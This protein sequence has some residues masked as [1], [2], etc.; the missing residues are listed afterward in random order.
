MRTWC[1]SWSMGLHVRGRNQWQGAGTESYIFA[2]NKR[3][4]LHSRSLLWKPWRRERGHFLAQ[5]Q[6]SGL[7]PT[8]PRDCCERGW[9][10][11]W[12]PVAANHLVLFYIF[13][14]FLSISGSPSS[15]PSMPGCVHRGPWAAG[16]CQHR[17]FVCLL[18]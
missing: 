7:C 3:E 18:S 5:S 13:S 17:L 1:N 12:S 6:I 10:G 4:G 9:E 16:C 11:R 2:T 8:I 14:C 15:P